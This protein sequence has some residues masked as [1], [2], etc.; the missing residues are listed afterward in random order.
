MGLVP[1]E[2]ILSNVT[3]VTFKGTSNNNS[4]FH[5]RLTIKEFFTEFDR[6]L[7]R[8]GSEAEPIAG[9]FNLRAYS[10]YC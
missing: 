7:L 2:D 4:R 6:A 5:D 9:L 1:V 8:C 3:Q 10:E